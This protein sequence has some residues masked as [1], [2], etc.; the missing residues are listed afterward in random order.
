MAQGPYSA[1]LVAD[2]E[3]PAPIAD[4]HR[5]N[6]WIATALRLIG[7]LSVLFGGAFLVIGIASPANWAIGDAATAFVGGFFLLAMAEAL[8][9]LAAI[10]TKLSAPPK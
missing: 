4:K 9:I 7:G 6:L 8:A 3:P 10:E 1:D 2:A 5:R